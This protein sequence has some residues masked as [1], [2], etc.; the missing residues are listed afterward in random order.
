MKKNLN[1]QNTIM[2]DGDDWWTRWR[3]EHSNAVLLGFSVLYPWHDDELY[4]YRHENG[5]LIKSIKQSSNI[6]MPQ[7]EVNTIHFFTNWMNI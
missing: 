5:S 2:E 7:L 6:K 4:L 1:L 3:D